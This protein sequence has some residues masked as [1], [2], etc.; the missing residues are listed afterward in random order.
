[1]GDLC[2]TRGLLSWI[3]D[4][5]SGDIELWMGH[6]RINHVTLHPRIKKFLLH[7]EPHG[8]TAVG[9]N[10]VVHR[11]DINRMYVSEDGN[12]LIINTW[13]TSSPGF[14]QSINCFNAEGVRQQT[15]EIIDLINEHFKETIPYPTTVDV[16]P[17]II[18]PLL[19]EQQANSFL[20]KL[21]TYRKKIL[22]CNGIIHS[23][24]SVK[25]S[26]RENIHRLVAK[27]PDCAFVY[28]E[29]ETTFLLDNE[30]FIDDHVNI[31]NLDEITYISTYCDVLVSRMSGP[32]SCIC[33]HEN[34]FNPNVAFVCIT[35]YEGL[36]HFYKGG[37]CKY[38][39]TSDVSEET[40]TQLISKHIG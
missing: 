25:F 27:N 9:F 21:S 12:H 37:T 29:K 2:Y 3:A 20:D 26:L 4:H 11:N 40:L 15:C 1:M 30:F 28:T 8:V 16:I 24:Q 38:E 14:C 18:R 39:W 22:L 33:V 10:W 19:Y 36:A 31:P 17:K 7:Q 13:I 35:N 23:G 6:D 32:G 5:A 34:L